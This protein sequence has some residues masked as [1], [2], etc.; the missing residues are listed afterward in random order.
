MD[1]IVEEDN[2]DVSDEKMPLTRNLRNHGRTLNCIFFILLINGLSNVN[3]MHTRFFIRKP[4]FCLSLN[5]FNFSR[6]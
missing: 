3:I 1:S 5:C 2:R 6:N 4:S